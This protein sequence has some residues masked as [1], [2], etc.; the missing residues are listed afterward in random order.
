VV[1]VKIEDVLR[2]LRSQEPLTFEEI[3]LLLG[4]KRQNVF[5]IYRNAMRKMR[6]ALKCRG[7]D[8]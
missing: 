6:V 4:M 1:V 8:V 2:S 3:G 5:S 7:L